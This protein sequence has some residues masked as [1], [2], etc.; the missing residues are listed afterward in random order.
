[1]AEPFEAFD[2]EF[3]CLTSVENRL[4]DFWR[5][6]GKRQN[7]ADFRFVDILMLGKG[8]DGSGFPGGQ[9]VEPE[10]GLSN[11]AAETR[12]RL[13]LLLVGACEHE[14]SFNAAA[15]KGDRDG[16]GCGAIVALDGYDITD[17]QDFRQTLSVHSDDDR[18]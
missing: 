1:M 7:A 12:I 9:L 11:Q 18:L 2:G 6:E 10:S 8:T 4:N 16:V 13:A 5:Q 3:F 15:L 14:L 17:L